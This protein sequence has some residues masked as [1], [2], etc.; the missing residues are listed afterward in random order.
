MLKKNPVITTSRRLPSGRAVLGGLLITLAIL[1][2]LIAGNV[3]E[4]ATFQD[5]VLANRDLAPGTVLGPDDVRQARLRLDEQVGFVVS[6]PASIYGS[7]LLGPLDTNEFIQFANLTTSTADGLAEVSIPVS[8]DS[9][10]AQLTPGELVSVLATY[11]GAPA[12]TEL[13][14]DRVTV[15]SYERA[16]DDFGS[17]TTAVLRLGLSDGET[18]ARIVL[19]AEVGEVSIVGI[20]SAPDVVIPEVVQ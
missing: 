4:D 9:A 13:V 12:T 15:I 19:A 18:A 14:A 11:G 2:V 3:R 8:T 16:S 1:G 5:V 7:I 20:G 17:S 10:P 6:D